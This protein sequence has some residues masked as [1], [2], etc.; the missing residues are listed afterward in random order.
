MSYLDGHYSVISQEVTYGTPPDLAILTGPVKGVVTDGKGSKL[1]VFYLSE[2]GVATGEVVTGSF[3]DSIAPYTERRSSGELDLNLPVRADMQTLSLYDTSTGTLLISSDVSPAFAT[4]CLGYP[5]DPDCLE[6]GT[7]PSRAGPIPDIM[8]V[9]AGLLVIAVLATG[10]IFYQVKRTRVPQSLPVPQQTVLVVDDSPDILD[11]VSSALTNDGYQCI[12]APGGKE[13]LDILTVQKPDVILLDIVMEPIDGWE[14]LRQIKKN[15]ATK[16]IPVLMLTG[17]RLTAHDAREY[18]ICI[19]DYIRKPFRE[20]DLS[21][22][23]GQILNRKKTFRESLAIAGK[24]GIDREKFCQ[25]AALST[26]VFVDKKIISILQKPDDDMMM[27]GT[28]NREIKDVISELIQNT[29]SKEMQM[30]EL[31]KEI[32]RAFTRNGFIP[33][34]W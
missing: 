25:S 23:I 34:S 32:T 20:E 1:E 10:G 5:K 3:P 21:A 6:R 17:N 7:V 16:S 29:R 12:T 9:A 33:P 22:A 4:F 13:C 15:S 11:V 2:P 14:T 8:L 19:E 24:A 31:K 27:A 30:E 26:R 18:H 28:P